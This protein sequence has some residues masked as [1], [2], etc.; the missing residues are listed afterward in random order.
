MWADL[1]PEVGQNVGNYIAGEGSDLLS[2]TGGGGDIGDNADVDI[3]DNEWARYGLPNRMSLPKAENGKDLTEIRKKPGMGNA[4]K[5]PGV[6]KFAGPHGTYPINNIDR[7]R[8]A[9][10]LAHH[11]SNPNAIKSKVYKEYPSLAAYGGTFGENKIQKGRQEFESGMDLRN[12]R[13][14]G[15]AN[16]L[17]PESGSSF[18]INPQV[19]QQTPM[20]RGSN[21]DPYSQ[22][23]LFESMGMNQ[24]GFAHGGSA[25]EDYEAEGGEVIM[26]EPGVQP[27]T[28]GNLESVDQSD[29]LS[30]LQGSSHE[31]GGEEV[32]GDG[33]QYVFSKTLKSDSWKMNFAK[34]AEK[35]GKN[36]SKYEKASE[37]GDQITK[38]TAEAMLQAWITKLADLKEEQ[39]S[40]RQEKFMEMV[41]SG[42][43]I[44]ELMEN[45]PDLTEQMIA[46]EQLAQQGGD[47]MAENPMG[48]IDMNALSETSQQLVGAK[49]GL[50]KY[51]NGGGDEFNPYSF[52]T[53][54]DEL[55]LFGDQSMDFSF[56]KD[57]NPKKGDVMDYLTMNAPKEGYTIDEELYEPDALYN[58]LITD[59]S[60]ERESYLENLNIPTE[61]PNK[62][63]FQ[64]VTDEGTSLDRESFE[65]EMAKYKL[66][67]SGLKSGWSENYGTDAGLSNRQYW[68]AR[69][70][71]L[72][73]EEGMDTER[74]T[75]IIDQEKM[76]KASA[77]EAQLELENKEIPLTNEQKA[78]QL[79][80]QQQQ[81]KKNA[82]LFKE[83]GQDLM[84]LGPTAWNFLQGNKPAEVEQHVG[85]KF[86][87]DI[88]KDL[89]LLKD[90]RID[91]LLEDNEESFNMLKYMA[92]QHGDGS[93]GGYMDT[94]LRGQNIKT[95]ADAKAWDSKL[96]LDMTGSKIAAESLFNLGE[97]DRTE[98]VRVSDANAQNRAAKKAF[99]AKGWEGL[100]GYSQLKQKMA[101]QA[102][103]DENLK[104]L[105]GD[106][107]PD[108][109]MYMNNDGTIDVEKVLKENPE[110]KEIF[111]KYFQD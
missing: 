38:S 17:G 79:I 5:Y 64:T 20:Y 101:N 19:D 100:S 60:S 58:K 89:A 84:N 46:E 28:S 88:L 43:P 12:L 95:K 40:A 96:K 85:N 39:E 80:Q 69:Y 37:E 106:I 51:K 66:Y 3:G 83:A 81:R 109:E 62:E 49:Y 59:Y 21:F 52:N 33:E 24:S 42:S 93:S 98:G 91:G 77:E 82:A 53:Y 70:N 55:G 74:A 107:Y 44:E 14:F 35:I 31:A 2:G 63:A 26:H 99:T 78:E 54:M 111:I 22:A 1:M 29:M 27:A 72:L 105:L 6:K 32:S 92:R 13:A 48:N 36:I 87:S 18:G 108:A 110:L 86:E 45:F 90:N 75:R 8:S 10:K 11:S 57:Y 34:A 61:R 103:R 71:Q 30:K 67:N 76:Q 25:N 68:K 15:G 16:M 73:S 97:R 56:G 9:L 50:P 47:Q 4:G 41:N 102:S 94:L 104:G 23:S 65:K 7:A